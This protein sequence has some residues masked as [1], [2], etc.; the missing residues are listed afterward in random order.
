MSKK[1]SNADARA[2]EER[3]Q[4]AYDNQLPDDTNRKNRSGIE[5]K[6]IY[7]PN[8]WN[9]GDYMED[10]GFPGEAPWTRG[11]YPTMHRGRAW[12]QRQLIGLATPE[13]YNQRMRKIVAAGATALSVIP[14]NSV[15]RGYDMDQVDPLLLGT[16]GTTI[17]TVDDMD[18]CLDGVPIE[19]TSIALN[20]PSPFTLLAFLLATARRRNISWDQVTGTSNQ[21]D[22][23]SHFVANH[24]FYRLELHGA[25]RVFVDHVAFANDHVP[26]WNPV[27]VV[28]QHMQQAGATP[29]EAMAFTLSTAIQ[30]ADD[31]MARGMDPDRFLPRFTFFFDI[32]ISFF[33]EVAKMRAGR[34]I[35]ARVVKDRLGA[36]NE[37]SQ[38]FK[39][40]AQTSGLDLTRQQPLNNIA[41]VTAQAMAGIFGGLQSMHTDSYDE[42]LSTPTEDA[43][44]IAIATQNI[45]RD[46]AHLSEVIDPLAGSFYVES[47]TNQMEEK[48]SEIMDK[49]DE[50]GGMFEAV[51]KGLVQQMIG[52]SAAT[53]Q[54]QVDSGEQTVVGVNRYRED[55]EAAIASLDRPPPELINR[56]LEKLK[57]FKADRSQD[58]V[59][60]SLD[61]LTRAAEDEG[62]NIF[63]KI[64]EAVEAGATNGEVCGRLR[65]D[66]GF[67]H[68]LV[69][70]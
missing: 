4:Q 22:F 66:M 16:C 24:M 19:K 56:H 28:G 60:K 29:A 67:G 27:S 14:C 23:I 51:R 43:A 42:V 38:R 46:E 37:T 13:Q 12:S 31:C 50:A 35:W 65:K 39:F 70:A 53:F 20:D 26:R 18:T 2:A 48:I 9:N 44:K 25:R 33:E 32:S 69:A 45:L 11:I 17:N 15:Y 5:V 63:E 1:P 47:M 52:E 57:K 36:K 55:E 8:D 34:R 59:A 54:D 10:L 68:P 30:F 21:S 58:L 62:I 6:P 64:V 7:S 49:V 41:R 3:W 61:E 40:H